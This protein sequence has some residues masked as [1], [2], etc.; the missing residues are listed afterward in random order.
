MGIAE[1][2]LASDV[3]DY[4]RFR[5]VCPAGGLAPCARAAAVLLTRAS[6]HATG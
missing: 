5:A 3:T 4:I 6:I 2:V 1:R